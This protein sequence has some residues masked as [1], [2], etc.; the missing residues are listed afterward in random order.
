MKENTKN[1]GNSDA[2]IVEFEWTKILSPKY[3]VWIYATFLSG[4]LYAAVNRAEQTYELV[5]TTKADISTIVH[6]LSYS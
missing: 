6:L 4:S 3:W 2:L 5:L 1:N